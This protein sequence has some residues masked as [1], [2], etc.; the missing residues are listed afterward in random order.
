MKIK[1][2]STNITKKCLS[3]SGLTVSAILIMVLA[4]NWQIS[5]RQPILNSHNGKYDFNGMLLWNTEVASIIKSYVGEIPNLK[6]NTN[7]L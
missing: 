3:V 5:K 1:D 7:F 2:P 6:K 4:S